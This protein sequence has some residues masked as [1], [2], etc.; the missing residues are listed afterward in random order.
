APDIPPGA[1]VHVRCDFEA[2]LDGWKGRAKRVTDGPKRGQAA[3]RLV[4]G[5]YVLPVEFRAGKGTLLSLWYYADGPLRLQIELTPKPG[6]G[7][8]GPRIRCAATLVP[9][10][11]RKWTRV[12]IPIIGAFPFDEPGSRSKG[13][14]HTTVKAGTSFSR[15]SFRVSYSKVLADYPTGAS[16]D[17]RLVLDDLAL[18]NVGEDARL[19]LLGRELA[20]LTARVKKL[21]STVPPAV[22]KD[23]SAG[24]KAVDAKVN[25]LTG[26]RSGYLLSPEVL[27]VA[28]EANA[29]RQRVQGLQRYFAAAAKT[30]GQAAPAFA[31]GT[32]SPAVRVTSRNPAY[33]FAGEVTGKAR[34][35]L[36]RGE[37]ESVQLVVL[38]LGRDLKQVNVSWTDLKAVRGSGTLPKSV[39]TCRLPECVFMPTT[40]R[41]YGWDY[42]RAGWTP[43]PL[44][45]YKPFDVGRREQRAVLLTARAPRDA[46][47]GEY[48]TTVTFKPANAPPVSV[49]LTVRVRDFTV[50]LR[51]RMRN[52]T[53]FKVTPLK[54]FY[55]RDIPLEQRRRWQVFL[56]DHRIQPTAQYSGN[57]SPPSKDIPYLFDHGLNMVLVGMVS[58]QK[59]DL[60][61]RL[62]VLDLSAVY[63]ADEVGK[64]SVGKIAKEADDIH[65]KYP[66]F[67]TMTGG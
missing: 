37:A 11:Q 46:P 51:G 27:A 22:V 34:I 52:Q 15:I 63:M 41:Q 26:K 8:K 20:D 9:L 54:K 18:Y 21:P 64:G 48:R 6:P 57:L 7:A 17:G 42:R 13:N 24:I 10:A 5:R 33:R 49:A 16:R 59:Y 29:C 25:S 62:G 43:D 4:D 39:L 38:P 44:M 40:T 56:L 14:T 67:R 12:K 32:A 55:G 53:N 35:D 65:V 2:G 58:R 47:A 60:L 30:S 19:K 23:L 31:L 36:A 66:G 1:E 61:E 50:P 3:L 45:P 28:E